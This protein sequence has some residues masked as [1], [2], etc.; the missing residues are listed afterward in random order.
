MLLEIWLETSLSV[1]L[2]S[3]Y[4]WSCSIFL[5]SQ[6]L[7]NQGTVSGRFSIAA[8]SNSF[9]HSPG[10]LRDHIDCTLRKLGALYRY[11][12]Q[13]Y[14]CGANVVILALNAPGLYDYGMSRS[15]LTWC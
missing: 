3:K 15:L 9:H 13:V 5:R 7:S 6:R 8:V 4:H 10:V 11:P 1:M 14:P 2:L 12:A